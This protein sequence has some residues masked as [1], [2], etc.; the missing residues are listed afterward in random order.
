MIG[1]IDSGSGGINVINECMKYYNEDFIYLV[2]NKNCPYGNKPLEEL[3]AILKDNINFLIK[4]YDVDFIILACNTISA[5]ADYSFLLSTK[6]PILKT[7]PKLKNNN[8]KLSNVL[9]FAT[10]NTLK[11]NKE[12]KLLK[13]N[14][15][16]VKTLY[17]KDL[18]KNIDDFLINKNEINMNIIKSKLK[19][20]F[21]RK[22]FK[23]IT[24]ISFG[25]THFKHIK[26]QILGIINGDVNIWA[27]EEDVAK[28]SQWLVRRKK[29]KSTI[30]IILTKRDVEFAAA[31]QNISNI[32]D[33]EV[34]FK[35]RLHKFVN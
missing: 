11:N 14:Y 3:K 13:L 6:T 31:I 27:C 4:N 26:E 2:D 29:A 32:K 10:K 21:K 5:V 19:K 35:N 23:N 22:K 15:P 1:V 30:K 33:G 12:I 18:P 9:I 16:Q 20:G 28:I 7:T 34:L 8:I 24:N 17:I 25:C